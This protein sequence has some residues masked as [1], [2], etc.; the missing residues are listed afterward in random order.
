MN[1]KKTLWIIAGVVVLLVAAFMT[2]EESNLSLT[3]KEPVKKKKSLIATPSSWSKTK[4]DGSFNYDMPHKFAEL[5]DLLRTNSKGVNAYSVN[6]L[7]HELVKAKNSPYLKNKKVSALDWVERGPAN[8]PGRVR[9]LVEVPGDPNFNTWLAGS[10]SGGVWKTSDGGTTWNHLT[11]ELPTLVTSSIALCESSPNIIYVGTGEKFSGSRFNGDGIFK[12]EDGG[13]TWQHVASASIDERFRNISRVIV[14]PNNPDLVLAT[15]LGYSAPSQ[16]SLIDESY[17]IRSVDGGQSWEVVFS[18]GPKIDQIIADPSNFLTQYISISGVGVFKSIDAGLTWNDASNGLAGGSRIELAISKT[19]TN[20]ICAMSLS[21][22]SGN[23]TDIFYS[24]DAASTWHLLLEENNGNNIDIL[25][26]QGIYNHAL[27]VNPFQNNVVYAGGIDLWKIEMTEGETQ[28]IP[29]IVRA[30]ATTY[31]FMEFINFGGSFLNGGLEEDT[32]TSKSEFVSVEIRFGPGLS[33]MA[34]RFTVPPGGGTNGDGGAGVPYTDYL[35]EEYVEV[36]FEVWDIDNDRQ[37]MVSFR[38]QE[39]DGEFNLIPNTGVNGREYILVHS[40]DY[41]DTPHPSIAQNGG[42]AVN[43]LYFLWPTVAEGTT[44]DANNLPDSKITI[45]YGVSSKS[46]QTTNLTDYY[47]QYQRLNKH[48]HVDH[49]QLIPIITDENNQTFKLLNG[50]DGGVYVSNISTFPGEQ[51]GDWTGVGRGFN[52]TQ[53]YGVDKGPGANVYIGGTQ[54]NGTQASDLDPTS[55]SD[56]NKVEEGDGFA[57][58]WNSKDGNSFMVSVYFNN[59]LRVVSNVGGY[60]SMEN[61]LEDIGEERAPFFTNLVM[62][63]SRPDM[64]YTYGASGVW[65]SPNFGLSWSLSEMEG[66]WQLRNIIKGAISEADNDIVWAGVSMEDTISIKVSTDGGLSFKETSTYTERTLGQVSG[67]TAHP[68]QPNT[69]YALFSFG[70][71]PKVLR[72]TDLGQTW[73]DI[74]GYGQNEVSSNGF[75]DVAVFDLLVMP[76]DPNTIWA[77]TEIGLIESTDNGQTWALANNGLPAVAVWRMKVVDQQI[78]LAT[79]GRGIWTVDIPELPENIL[80]PEINGAST[81]MNGDLVISATILGE[82]DSVDLYIDAE[83]LLSFKPEALQQITLSLPGLSN[84]DKTIWLTA[85]VNNRKLHTERLTVD[86]YP[87]DEYLT[88]YG[89]TFEDSSSTADFIGNMD[90]KNLSTFNNGAI[91]T[92]HPYLTVTNYTYQ[93]RS[94]II[95]A[96][97]PDEARLYYND[98]AIV[99]IGEEGTSFGEQEFWDYVV[100][101]GSKDGIN[102]VP[103]ENGYDANYDADWLSAYNNVQEG[104]PSLYRSHA[105]N[106]HDSFNAGDTIFVRFRLFSDPAATGWGWAI[107]NVFIQQAPLSANLEAEQAK[108]DMQIIPNPVVGTSMASIFLQRPGEVKY[109]IIDASGRI[110]MESTKFFNQKGVQ[111]L[112]IDATTLPPGTYILE[113]ATGEVVRKKKM[114]VL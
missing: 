36:P 95:I 94:P 45:N 16:F 35:Y 109:R 55:S 51:E 32:T 3:S 80:G 62:S 52:T 21:N 77:G 2:L 65:R 98:I 60:I 26:G 85:H 113:V 11:K 61:G 25:G 99:E 74:S 101:E 88:S 29:R 8:V 107:D 58:L 4:L 64:V 31:P 19:N 47:E 40:Q 83:R 102:W 22:F 108:D 49:H 37:M 71:S 105:V 15:S 13:N 56:Y 75:P 72:T 1:M 34:H 53:F 91:H 96:A 110:W 68:T 66:S 17:V 93:L 87:I 5:Y 57:A 20:I 14:D 54:D 76:H 104:T 48:V 111:V 44:W 33:Q 50:N 82:Y 23:E 42:A 81:A 59:I 92:P 78:V 79:H 30:I 100:V 63:K 7:Y 69:A 27:A 73:E 70:K 97:D 84:G 86:Y 12:S 10:A 39:G 103:F 41:N 114:L 9:A 106:L 46:K 28:Y 89:T 6:H 43:Q 67:L 112:P 18:T 38:D 24:D 90:W